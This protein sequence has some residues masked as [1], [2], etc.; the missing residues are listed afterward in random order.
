MFLLWEHKMEEIGIGSSLMGRQ[1]GGLRP[2]TII[3]TLD[4]LEWLRKNKHDVEKYKGT[5][6]APGLSHGGKI[7]EMEY[8]NYSGVKYAVVDREKE[9]EMF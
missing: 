7:V 5:H 3:V 2:H 9:K 4:D 8:V 1:V 6:L